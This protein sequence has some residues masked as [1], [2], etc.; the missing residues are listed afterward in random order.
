MANKL[1]SYI[2]S[3]DAPKVENPLPEKQAPKKRSSE[4]KAIKET[5]KAEPTA[6]EERR[7]V[8]ILGLFLLL[9][10]LYLFT[11]FTSFLFTWQDDQSVVSGS[12]LGILFD[13][14]NHKTENWLGI[15]GAM[16][17]HIFLHRG[18]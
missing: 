9:I 7:W 12:G 11:A 8:K 10:S 2:P 1:R 5:S 4:S 14:Q 16:L 17:S 15:L 3:Q 6:L 13:A 18:F